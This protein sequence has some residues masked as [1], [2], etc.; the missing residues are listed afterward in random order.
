MGT[1]FNGDGWGWMPSLRG[2]LGMGIN[3]RPRAA[4]YSAVGTISLV[5]KCLTFLCRSLGHFGT[6]AE[7]SRHFMK[8]PKS[9]FLSSTCTEVYGVEN[10]GQCADCAADNSSSAGFW[11]HFNIVY[12]LTTDTSALVPKCLGQIGGA[13]MFLYRFTTSRHICTIH[14][15]RQTTSQDILYIRNYTRTFTF[16]S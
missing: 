2:R 16:D 6:S 13:F 8:R 3:Y 12:L 5:P 14:R 4:L 15:D 1:G 9:R 11:A 7:L 10:V